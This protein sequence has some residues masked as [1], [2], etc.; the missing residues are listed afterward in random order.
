MRRPNLAAIRRRVDA[1]TPGTW[2]TGDKFGRGTLGSHSVVISGKHPNLELDPYKNGRH[3]AAFIAHARQDIPAL[4]DEIDRLKTLITPRAAAALDRLLDAYVD[5]ED[6][7]PGMPDL[8]ELKAK[9]QHLDQD[10]T[11]YHDAFGDGGT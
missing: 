11:A 5:N 7:D 3:D 9:L 10:H 1:A 2:K 8:R 6:G 4:L